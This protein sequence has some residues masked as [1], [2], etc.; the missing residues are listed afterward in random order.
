VELY[1][2]KKYSNGWQVEFLTTSEKP[3]HT[4]NSFN[5]IYH[6]EKGNE[7]Y[8]NHSSI[9]STLCDENGNNI[10]KENQFIETLYL[11]DYLEDVVYLEPLFTNT[12]KL[13]TPI[14]IKIN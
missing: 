14:E 13:D 7:Y 1:N 5:S 6:D 4:F 3:N 2:I 12:F 9:T 11:T 10:I 8:I